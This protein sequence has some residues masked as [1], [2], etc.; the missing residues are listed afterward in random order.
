VARGFDPTIGQIHS[1]NSDSSKDISRASV[2]PLGAEF[3]GCSPF[4]SLRAVL[5]F[6]TALHH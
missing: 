1:M 4:T 5:A 3:H 2:S 6:V